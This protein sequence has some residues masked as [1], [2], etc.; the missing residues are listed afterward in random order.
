MN[1]SGLSALVLALAAVPERRK[2]VPKMLMRG[3]QLVLLEP[4]FSFSALRSSTLAAK[5][6]PKKTL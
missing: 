4:C 5:N 3:S 2:H 6:F 1:L